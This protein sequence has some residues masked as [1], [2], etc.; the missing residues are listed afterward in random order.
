MNPSDSSETKICTSPPSVIVSTSPTSV[1]HATR[2]EEIDAVFYSECNHKFTPVKRSISRMDTKV[3][4][5]ARKGN[6][7][8]LREHSDHLHQLLTP[9]KNTVLHVYIACVGSA[10]LTKS[11]EL[12]KSAEVVVRE[13]LQMCQRLLLQPNESGD[14]ALHLAARHGRADIVEV[15][16]RAAKDWHGDLEEGILSKE[17]CDQFLIRRPN[18]EKNTALHEAVR[19]NHLDVVKILTGKD[20]ELLYSANDAGKTPLYMAAERGYDDLVFEMLGTCTNPSYE[21]PDGLTALHVAAAYGYEKITRRLLETKRTLAIASDERGLTPLHMAVFKGHVSIVKQILEFDH[22]PAYIGDTYKRTPAH[23]AARAGHVKIMKQLIVYCPDSFEL[24]DK[25]GRNALHYAISS[26]KDAVEEFVLKDPWLSSVLLNGKDSLGNTPLHKIATS[27]EYDGWE[28]IRDPR[29][30]KMA[31]NK[32]KKNALNIIQEST[33]SLWKRSQCKGLEKSGAREGLQVSGDKYDD[34]EVHVDRLDKESRYKEIKESHLVVS[35]LIATVTFAA[36]FTMPG[37]YHSEEGPDQGFAVLSRIAAFKLFVITNTLAMTMSSCAVMI[38][39]FLS[40]KG[41]HLGSKSHGNAI[42][43][44]SFALMAMLV[45]FISGTY[46]VLGD[47]SSVL[48]ITV[49]GIGCYYFV[50]GFVYIYPG[51]H[52]FR[53]SIFKLIHR[54]VS[55]L[56]LDY[57]FIY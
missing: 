43:L 18:E 42:G 10:R 9:T 20:L 46:A 24:V 52:R 53:E 48:A 16:I 26:N 27:Q 12:L 54:L 49:S 37:G 17:V 45:A 3:F 5:A 33:D 7:D 55:F 32:E 22:S 13:M 47:P 23:H 31:F 2:R 34:T 56:N 28:F 8:A 25:E 35:T 6:I 40:L 39:F 41:Q 1:Y 44:T 29:V 38:R 51:F 30:D 50:F 14:T 57:Y 21:G 11:K 36:G 19:F 15:L 4:E